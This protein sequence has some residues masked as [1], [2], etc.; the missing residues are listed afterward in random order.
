MEAAGGRHTRV[1]PGKV[2]MVKPKVQKGEN[3][4]GKK[5]RRPKRDLA[6][7]VACI[8]KSYRPKEVAIGP[9]AGKEEW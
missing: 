3:S 1:Y 4:Q 8:P 5:V 6:E 9:P 7:L 2:A